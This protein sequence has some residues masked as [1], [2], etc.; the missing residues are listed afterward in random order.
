MSGPRP[1]KPKRQKPK[2]EWIIQYLKDY[3]EKPVIIFSKFT[4]YLN[5][6]NDN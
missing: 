6:Y 2:T 5:F 1:T 3:P 4:T